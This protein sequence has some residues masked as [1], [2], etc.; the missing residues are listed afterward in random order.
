M[1][2]PKRRSLSALIKPASSL[3][4]LNCSYCF[5]L[6]KRALY[7]WEDNPRMS[8]ETW[9]EFLRQYMSLCELPYFFVWQ[10]G[11][12][13]L[14]GLPFY[15]SAVELEA[16][17]A[18]ETNPRQRIQIGNAIQTNA[19]LL[20]DAWARFFKEWHFFVG[21]SI[22]GPP[23]WH[24]RYRMDA[25]GHGT[26]ARVMAG[27]E[28]LRRHQ[29]D[30][31]V[32]VVVSKANAQHPRELLRWLVEHEFDN[33][34]FSPCAERQQ[35]APDTDG[36]V[37]PESITPDEHRRFLNELFDAWLEI[38]VDKVRIRWFDNLVQMLWGRPSQMCQ[39]SPTCGYIVVEHNGDCYPCDFLVE[40]DW[41]LGN[42]HET[43]LGEMVGGQ[44]FTALSR[45]KGHLHPRCMECPWLPLC[46]GECP[47]YRIVNRGS[48]DH[49]LPYFCDSYRRFYERNYGRLE[50][51]AIHMGRKLGLDV[52]EGHLPPVQRTPLTAQVM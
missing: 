40:P 32:L 49:S 33:L 51:I 12:P 31:N 6:P 36:E 3:C 29:I 24:D 16:K 35:N 22:D 38:G 43:S 27:V 7:P 8:L 1:E 37:T 47:R 23:E 14:M 13:T 52:P 30:F 17:V 45:A 5:Y 21:V 48:A 26:H 50:Q 44:G 10:G 11:E 4:N 46:Y 41:K 2:K 28:V 39:S 9:E 18:R 15:Q 25:S 34:Q 42:I 19:V 20:D